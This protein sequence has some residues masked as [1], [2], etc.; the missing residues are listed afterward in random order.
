LR[1][2]S[3]IQKCELCK[4]ELE[5]HDRAIRHE[6]KWYHAKCYRSTIQGKTVIENT[7]SKKEPVARATIVKPVVRATI[8]K[9]VVR[10]TKATIV[11]TISKQFAKVVEPEKKSE[12]ILR[13]S[14]CKKELGFHDRTIRHEKKWY[15]AECYRSAIQE[16]PILKQSAR[17]V[18]LETKAKIIPKTSK[19]V[20][21]IEA[22]P[23][24]PKKKIFEST[25]K[26]KQ[27][28]EIDEEAIPKVKHDPV[29]ILLAATIFIFL[30]SGAY[31][32]LPGFSVAAM[33][34]GG[35]LV[36][37]QLLDAK[38]TSTEKYRHAKWHAPAVFPMFLLILPFVLGGILAYEG[39][40]AWD[41]AYRAIILWGLTIIFWSTLLMVPLAVY[42]KNIESQVP[43]TPATPLV[44]IIIP[45]Y[46]EEKV[47]GNTIESTLEI[48]YP[49]KDI[50]VVD[51]GSKDNTL[52]IAKRY[53]NEGV[54]VLHKENGGKASALN[55]ALTFAKGEIVAVLDADTLASRNS[56]TE[57]VKIFE[58]D[59]DVAAVA[60]NIKVRNKV[61]WITWCQALE[62]VAGIQIARR[63]FDLF[64]AITI[65]PGAL[66]SFRKSILMESGAYDKETIVEDFDTTIKILKSGMIVRGTTKSVAYT[67]APNTLM[68]FYK[69]RKRWYRGNL[70]VLTK[71]RN[72]LTNPRFGFLQKLAFPYML[73]AMII[74]PITGFIVLGSAI[75]AMIEG[76]YV[77]VLVSFGFFIILQYLM[78]ALGVR[79]DGDDPKLILFSIFFNFGYKQLLDYI[80]L[81]QAI[82]QLFKRKASWTSAKRI[83]LDEK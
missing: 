59:K 45:A 5:F 40:T 18:E 19:K 64:G 41:S 49:N 38:R 69:Q 25:K 15:H 77:F 79:I 30:F 36:M 50:I 16:K 55:Y 82:A 83:G 65:V 68:D 12:T 42:S 80:L 17:V 63:A 1:N 4:K 46:N 37:Y 14:H 21:Q 57:I 44:S 29:L 67:E 66:G 62:Y 9:P 76:D 75:L 58:N 31:I 26:L 3:L 10:I 70:Q 72:A 7:Y 71:H 35:F 56:L 22:K 11:K 6:K 13:C 24:P 81:R 20:I 52:Q 2:T 27:V 32:L 61:N 60:G 39:F 74:L 8:V 34:L 43:T 51:D 23:E 78:T 28:S 73:I 53:E 54:K 33:L 48:A 47:I